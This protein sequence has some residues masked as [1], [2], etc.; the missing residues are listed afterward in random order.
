MTKGGQ[1]V[2]SRGKEAWH[3]REGQK[4][5]LRR[6]GSGEKQHG[7]QRD[8][9][10]EAGEERRIKITEEIGNRIGKWKGGGGQ[11]NKEGNEEEI[12]TCMVLLI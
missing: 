6:K 8:G 2:G 1:K 3:F 5:A 9:R 11:G 10:E 12:R 7:G 4:I